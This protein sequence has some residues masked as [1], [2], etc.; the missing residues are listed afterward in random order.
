MIGATAVG[1]FVSE[2]IAWMR[3]YEEF[4]PRADKIYDDHLAELAREAKK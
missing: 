1:G 4:V 3:W 2:A